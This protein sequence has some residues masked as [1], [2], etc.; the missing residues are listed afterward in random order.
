MN[1]IL[2]ALNNVLIEG[3]IFC[4]FEKGFDYKCP[5]FAISFV[6]IGQ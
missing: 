5:T 4:D 6:A 2:N 1:E 3:D